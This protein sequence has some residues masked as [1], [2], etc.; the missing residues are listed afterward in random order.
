MKEKY[1]VHKSG[2]IHLL[3]GCCKTRSKI[4]EE[5]Y[6]EVFTHSE[7]EERLAEKHINWHNCS[8]CD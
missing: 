6:F 2:T 1:R 7:A 3:A 4:K 5:N 8:L